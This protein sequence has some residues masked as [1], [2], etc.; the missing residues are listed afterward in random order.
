MGKR[1]SIELTELLG[2]PEID[3][4]IKTERH[5]DEDG[6][7]ETTTATVAFDRMACD[8]PPKGLPPVGSEYFMMDVEQFQ[9]KITLSM[10]FNLWGEVWWPLMA[11]LHN[12]SI[13]YRVC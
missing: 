8:H 13:P 1:I 3:V 9:G 11:H 10:D 6:T 4:T 2:N 5:T 12:N 7:Y